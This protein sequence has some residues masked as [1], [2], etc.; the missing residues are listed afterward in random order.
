M[1]LVVA[2]FTLLLLTSCRARAPETFDL[3]TGGGVN[4]GNGGD[5]RDYLGGTTWFQGNKPVRTCIKVA[6]DFDVG[7]AFVEEEFRK[8]A[9][10]WRDYFAGRKLD[11]KDMAP[12]FNYEV[13]A[14]CAG[15]EDLVVYAGTVDATIAEARKSYIAPVAFS[16]REAFDAK[17]GWGKGYIW[18]APSATLPPLNDCNS[19]L[20]IGDG[21]LST[22]G[23]PGNQPRDGLWKVKNTLFGT[24]LHELGHVHGVRHVP[25]TIMA[26]DFLRLLGAA[27]DSN[28][29]HAQERLAQIDDNAALVPFLRN[30]DVIKGVFGPAADPS[31]LG[32]PDQPKDLFEK[33]VGRAPEG[34]VE[35]ELIVKGEDVL[36]RLKD[37][38]GDKTLSFAFGRRLRAQHREEVFFAAREPKP[39]STMPYYAHFVEVASTVQVGFVTAA[40]GERLPVLLTKNMTGL[41]GASPHAVHVIWQD[42][43][44]ELFQH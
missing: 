41:T 37:E 27:I 15:D 11:M 7:R 23:C 17:I 25:G 40:D 9:A 16:H 2:T 39:G 44:R 13:H 35:A 21:S 22:A 10:T 12:S 26:Q 28:S 33:L 5:L 4:G 24:L 3:K 20:T 30:G 6:A 18:I 34:K 32:E 14:A 29:G 31:G 36:V 19:R 42:K 8:A 38:L 43:V 1:R